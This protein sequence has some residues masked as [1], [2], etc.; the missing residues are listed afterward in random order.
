[1]AQ[2]YIVG[3]IGIVEELELKGIQ[4]I[5]GPEDA[6][7]K[8]ELKPGFALPHDESVCRPRP[9]CLPHSRVYASWDQG[10][11][12]TI[13]AT[14]SLVLQKPPLPPHEKGCTGMSKTLCFF[15]LI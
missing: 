14:S 11:Q 6:D 2:V 15:T 5:G 10:R 7:K 8:I 12:A 3:E 9:P 1:M 13:P 4:H